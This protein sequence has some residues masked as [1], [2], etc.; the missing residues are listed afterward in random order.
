MKSKERRQTLICV[1]ILAYFVVGTISLTPKR[2]PIQS[3]LAPLFTAF[4]F[5]DME[6]TWPMFSPPPQANSKLLYAVEYEEGW[7]S[8]VDVA[9]PSVETLQNNFVQPRGLFRVSSHLRVSVMKDLKRERLHEKDG[10]AFYYQQLADYFCQ[11]DG[12]IEGI[13]T[14]R[15]YVATKSMVPYADDEPLP[16]DLKENSSELTAQKQIYE[17]SCAST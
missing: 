15:L 4:R 14:I 16:D 5:I 3:A 6:Q 10:R 1:C 17:Q 13:K 12:K 9:A 11:G 2:S 7:S 8:L